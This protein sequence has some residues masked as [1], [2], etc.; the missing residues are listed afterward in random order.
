MRNHFNSCDFAQAVLL[1]LPKSLLPDASSDRV[2]RNPV[3]FRLHQPRSPPRTE[4]RVQPQRHGRLPT[5]PRCHPR[6]SPPQL[7]HPDH[8]H[9]NPNSRISIYYDQLCTYAAYKGQQITNDVVLLPFYQGHQDVNVLSTTL[10][11]T[12][13]PVA[14]SFGYEVGRDQTARKM[15]LNL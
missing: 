8:H 5:R 10:S 4:A 12:A 15:Y 1:R 14:P 2:N 7:H 9:H 3:F 13:M 6:V 11:G